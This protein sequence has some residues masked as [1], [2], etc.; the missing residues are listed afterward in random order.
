M[1][2]SDSSQMSEYSAMPSEVPAITT[3]Q[4]PKSSVFFWG[5]FSSKHTPPTPPIDD[6]TKSV[7]TIETS[8]ENEQL[9][10]ENLK[11]N[12]IHEE[13]KN[14][15][16]SIT[17]QFEE[18]ELERNS[19]SKQVSFYK[20]QY[21]EAQQKLSRSE[22]LNTAYFS[23]LYENSISHDAEL[24]E[25]HKVLAQNHQFEESLLLETQTSRNAQAQLALAQKS[26]KKLTVQNEHL[27][28]TLDT[29]QQKYNTVCEKL[30][31]MVLENSKWDAIEQDNTTLTNK[32]EEC[33][34][35]CASKHITC[36]KLEQELGSA[37]QQ[38]FMLNAELLQNNN[39][40]L[41]KHKDYQKSKQ[42]LSTLHDKMNT[43]TSCVTALFKKIT[44]TES[45][46]TMQN[47]QVIDSLLK[48]IITPNTPLTDN[49]KQHITDVLSHTKDDVYLYA[50]KNDM[51]WLINTLRPNNIHT[52]KEKS[53]QFLNA[54][55]D[56]N[57]DLMLELL[58]KHLESLDFSVTDNIGST[59]LLYMFQKNAPNYIIKKILKMGN[60]AV[61]QCNKDRYN[62]LLYAVQNRNWECVKLMLDTIPKLYLGQINCNSSC[63]FRLAF[64]GGNEDLAIDILK[65]CKSQMSQGNDCYYNI[66]VGKKMTNL[67]KLMQISHN[68]LPQHLTIAPIRRGNDGGTSSFVQLSF[69]NRD[70]H[71]PRLIEM[72]NNDNIH[73]YQCN[74]WGHDALWHNCER[75]RVEVVERLIAIPHINLNQCNADGVNPLMT[76]IANGH[77]TVAMLLLDAINHGGYI[78]LRQVKCDGQSAYDLAITQKMQKVADIISNI[79]K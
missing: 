76:A 8:Q 30:N 45:S 47:L 72:L 75:G 38:V 65:R 40:L 20:S 28:K 1:T 19:L 22:S 70:K 9:T 37:K 39:E 14:K 42:Q 49:D 74:V 69:D 77:E 15:M 10:I 79:L 21:H 4:P 11:I 31:A 59:A 24:I 33:M 7:L 52:S 43:L 51:H 18:Q 46:N 36:Q 29:K 61:N 50:L 3:I 55:R 56:R 58:D 68:E 2:R 53:I 73:P 67:E 5:I 54:A 27:K 71:C 60:T 66:V 62:A 78:N 12:E 16:T 41:S 32:V 17:E 64:D 44:N 13:F 34:S 63:A 26:V 25:Y 35:V 48:L 57:L 23:K 6:D